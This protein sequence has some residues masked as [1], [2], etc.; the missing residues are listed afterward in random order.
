MYLGRGR[1]EFLYKIYISIL[2]MDKLKYC[3]N[4]MLVIASRGEIYDYFIKYYWVPF[5]EYV[6]K[7][8][9]IYELKIIL[10]YGN[11]DISDLSIPEENML[12]FTDIEDNLIPGCLLKTI[13]AFEYIKNNY[14][15][16]KII[17]TNLSS[18]FYI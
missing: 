1:R 18:F 15:Y 6:N 9:N 10:L 17:R 7:T 12:Q 11:S 8:K 3:N 4:I 16:K 5:I 2:Y 14:E 13:K